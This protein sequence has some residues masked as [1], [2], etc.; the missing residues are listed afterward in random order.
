M[1]LKIILGVLYSMIFIFT[2]TFK[3]ITGKLESLLSPFKIFKLPIKQMSLSLSLALKFIPL[4]FNQA[5]KILKS[6]ASRGIDF[7]HSNLKGKVLAISSMLLPMFIL[8]LKRADDIVDCLE[9]RSYDINKKNKI[10]KW[11]LFDKIMLL[12]HLLLLIII[13]WKGKI[14]RYLITFAYDG[15]N[16][17]VFKNNQN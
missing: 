14:M 5:E 10:N 12:V 15:S 1:I 9:V 6:Q 2:T 11:H 7:K 3:E 16:S 17:V 8:S 4:I 13:Y